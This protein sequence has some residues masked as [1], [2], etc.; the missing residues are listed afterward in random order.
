MKCIVKKIGI[1]FL[2]GYLSI[3][4]FGCDTIKLENAYETLETTAAYGLGIEE[5]E[6][7]AELFAEELCVGG[8]E[9]LLSD[10]VEEN[11]SAAAGLFDLENQEILYANGIH[12]KIYPASTTKI[13]TAYLALKYGDLTQT[14]TV[15]ESAFSDLSWDSSVCGLAVGDTITLEQLIY[16]LLL[17]SGNDAA[18][19]IAET[20]SGSLEAFAE[21]MN[22][23]AKALGATNTHFV[24]AHGLHDEEHYTTVYDLYLIFQAALENEFFC[25]VIN[26]STYRIELKH[27][28]G[29]STW[30]KWSNSNRY[31]S[32]DTASPTGVTVI[33]GKTGTTTE[34]GSCLV[35]LSENE[36][37]YSYISIVMKGNNKT[38]L[39]NQMTELLQLIFS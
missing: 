26:T 3:A 10:S 12:E 15:S 17:P 38:A 14:V 29:T 22:E 39:Y 11:L 36:E 23:E 19:V 7:Y 27:S 33:G 2:A 31:I 4:C 21:L 28:D 20:I 37:G 1:C 30:R 9:D 6:A 34:A 24:N 16:G 8:N 18:N 5:I 35:L 25:Q 32:G 13:M